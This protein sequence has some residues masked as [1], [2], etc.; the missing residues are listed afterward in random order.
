MNDRY[1]GDVR[2]HARGR[3]NSMLLAVVAGIGLLALGAW[4][5][6]RRDMPADDTGGRLPAPA[7][8]AVAE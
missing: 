6:I 4:L 1:V 8:S 7:A 5:L 2:V 3:T